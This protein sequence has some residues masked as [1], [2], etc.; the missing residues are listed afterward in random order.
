CAVIAES[1]P[2]VELEGF[3]RL[4]LDSMPLEQKQ[5]E[6]FEKTTFQGKSAYRFTVS[7]TVS[8]VHVRYVNTMFRNGDFV[9]QLI[10]W[11]AFSRARPGF[12]EP[13]LRAFTILPGKV[14]GRSTK[15]KVPDA[16]GVGWLVRDGVF[17]SAAL[18]VAVEPR[19]GWR[20]T[21]GGEL[22]SMNA[23]AEVGLLHSVPDVYMVLLV[24]RA[25]GV[26]KKAFAKST[27]NSWEEGTDPKP[28]GRT[29]KARIG[30]HEV[31]FRGFTPGANPEFEFLKAVFFQDDLCMQ[32]LFWYAASNRKEALAVIPDGVASLKLLSDV[33]TQA[34]AKELRS[35]PDPENQVGSGFSL[36]R[37][38]YRDF[39]GKFIFRKPPG[40]YWRV[41]AG[42][43]AR[44]RNADARIYMEHPTLGISGLVIFEPKAQ[45][46][47]DTF[48]RAVAGAMFGE[49]TPVVKKGGRPVTVDGGQALATRGNI[50][51]EGL[52]LR[53]H[54]VTT[55]RNGLAYQV[56]L[57]GLERNVRASTK[58][59]EAVLGSFRFDPKLE[60][61]VIEDEGI[62][63]VRFGFAFKPGL[64]GFP[65]RDVTPP[66]MAAI[67][68]FHTWASRDGAVMLL[69]LCAM[70]PGQDADWFRNLM[71]QTAKQ[72]FGAILR[73]T[74]ST[75]ETTV[76]GLTALRQSWPE[77]ANTN[78]IILVTRDRTFYALFLMRRQGFTPEQIKAITG[79]FRL[80]D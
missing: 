65:H 30:T 53:Y 52:E 42:M 14:T 68:A 41:H 35:G 75:S 15:R 9:F 24:E 12:H 43:G 77:G 31:T 74:P 54:L 25:A 29:L 72:R 48:H 67:G 66:S 38:V 62:Q 45:F 60:A 39:E 80:L 57:Y 50:A 22:E 8:E 28:N 11:T 69:A 27:M 56:I 64:D 78:D 2:D 33:E 63:D 58:A 73:S 19:G 10:A 32:V 23:D 4:V 7:G 20:V 76:A 47:A 44:A 3:A 79:S 70:Q 1:A 17:K 37:G 18:Q 49:D 6:S 61:Q 34:V 46:T 59:I 71:A 36:R 21:V 26:D 51:S 40:E 16:E 5:N 55:I 13:T